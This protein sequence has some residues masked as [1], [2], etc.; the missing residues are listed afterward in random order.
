MPIAEG[1]RRAVS[2][3]PNTLEAVSR[4]VCGVF[5]E[6]RRKEAADQY[7]SHLNLSVKEFNQNKTNLP[8]MEWS[9]LNAKISSFQLGC[10]LLVYGFDDQNDAHIFCV[11]DPGVLHYEDAAGFAAIGSG[12]YRALSSLFWFPMVKEMMIFEALYQV[13]AA[14]FS[15]ES[16]R[17]VGDESTFAFVFN[18]PRTSK[19]GGYTPITHPMMIRIRKL[20]EKYGRPRQPE[21]LLEKLSAAL[22]ENKRVLDEAAVTNRKKQQALEKALRPKKSTSRKSKSGQ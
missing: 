16:A 19:V 10:Q 9:D 20:W 6:Q 5:Q 15:A 12:A 1:A 21:R 14:K 17:G 11:E 7:L 8:P 4:A 2:A 13:C 3:V 22:E 18:P